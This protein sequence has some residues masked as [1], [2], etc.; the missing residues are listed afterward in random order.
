MF[1]FNKR[2]IRCILGYLYDFFLVFTYEH[3]ND[4]KAKMEPAFKA[5]ATAHWK[6]DC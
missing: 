5:V 1:M 3:K 4:N 6:F 2:R